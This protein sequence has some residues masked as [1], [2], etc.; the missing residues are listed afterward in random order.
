VPQPHR[1]PDQQSASEQREHRPHKDR[2]STFHR[3]ALPPGSPGWGGW[4]PP[5]AGRKRAREPAVNAGQTAPPRT[6][7]TAV[8]SGIRLLVRV[9]STTPHRAHAFGQLSGAKAPGLHNGHHWR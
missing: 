3:Y 8:G 6:A 4:H 5:E 9:P 2:R 1:G 7:Q